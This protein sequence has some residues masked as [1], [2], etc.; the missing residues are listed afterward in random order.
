MLDGQ[1]YP[2]VH[3]IFYERPIDDVE[4]KKERGLAIFSS[5]L[6]VSMVHRALKIAASNLSVSARSA[7]TWI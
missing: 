7:L 3:I 4:K 2:H 1:H 5:I 6:F